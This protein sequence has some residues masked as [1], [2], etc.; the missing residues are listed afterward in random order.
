MIEL[1]NVSKVK[2]GRRIVD[3]IDLRLEGGIT[4][5][6]G[7]N[8]AGKTTV[9][10]LVAGLDRPTT[11]QALVDGRPMAGWGALT[12]G[13]GHVESSMGWRK[14]DD[15][16]HGQEELLDGVSSAGR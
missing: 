4:A 13:C 10:R 3:G 16:D 11:G 15:Q 9:M 6:L 14:R 5:L 7:P 2:G 8:G 1:A 12:P